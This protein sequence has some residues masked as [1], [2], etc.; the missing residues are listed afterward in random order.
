LMVA[1]TPV[2]PMTA[3]KAA[4]QCGHAAEL[5]LTAMGPR[6]AATWASAGFAV[7]VRFPGPE[8]WAALRSSAPVV[9]CDA[10]HTEVPPGTPT[11]LATW[12]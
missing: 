11:V 7:D 12:R 8:G 3:G 9:V 4:A 10:G 5:A 2:V 6:R 1:V